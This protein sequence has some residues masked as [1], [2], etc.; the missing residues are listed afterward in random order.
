MAELRVM[1]RHGKTRAIYLH[2]S[3]PCRILFPLPDDGQ[4]FEAVFVLTSGGLAGG[5]RLRMGFE[6]AEKTAL[7]IAGQA[8][9]KVYRSSGEACR[10][11]VGLAAEAGARIE[12]IP[13][14]TILFDGARLTRRHD[15]ALAADA[16]FIG[17]DMLVFGR[18]AHG[19]RL[20]SGSLIDTWRVRRSGRLVWA[21]ALRLEGDVAAILDRPFAFGRAAAMATALYCGPDAEALLKPARVRLNAASGCTAATLVNGVLLMR[22]L[23]GDAVVARGVLSD[24]L[25]WLRGAAL[26]WPEH[27]PRVWRV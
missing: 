3:D 22:C 5:D 26:D 7:S 19:E 12:Y 6:A 13:Q 10:I 21:D 2:Q 4:P 14:E 8:A 20:T 27:L 16:R 25:A 23:S 24:F 18:A 9:E 15:V 11:E 1:L 17:A